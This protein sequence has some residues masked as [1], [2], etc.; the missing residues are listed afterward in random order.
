[1]SARRPGPAILALVIIGSGVR[2]PNG[3]HPGGLV[4]TGIPSGPK[5]VAVLARTLKSH[6]SQGSC[7]SDFE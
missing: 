1:L 6:H 3:R 5:M 2:V 7:V 4:H